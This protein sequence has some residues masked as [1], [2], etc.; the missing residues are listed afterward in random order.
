[1]NSLVT[2][3]SETFPKKGIEYLPYDR[4]TI[5]FLSKMLDKK[6]RVCTA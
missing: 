5:H 3:A 2:Q 6:V 1:M 4:G